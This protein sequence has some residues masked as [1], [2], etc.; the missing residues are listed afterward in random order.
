MGL[1]AVLAADSAAR[2]LFFRTSLQVE[3]T[4]KKRPPAGLAVTAAVQPD[5]FW[6]GQAFEVTLVNNGPKALGTGVIEI[7]GARCLLREIDGDG[8]LA[9]GESVKVYSGWLMANTGKFRPA[10]PQGLPG[11]V[12]LYFDE[13]TFEWA[14]SQGG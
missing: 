9:P 8:E 6:L 11:K 5:F 14:V 1:V 12:V 4:G 13:G 3:L 7:N 2:A 10:A